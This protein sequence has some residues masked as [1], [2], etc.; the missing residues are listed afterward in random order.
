[1]PG[2]LTVAAENPGQPLALL[3]VGA[4][5]GL[6]LN[7]D[8]YRYRYSS[9]DEFGPSNSGV[10]IECDAR[11]GL[12]SLPSAF[13]RVNFRV[14]IDL[15]PV[16]LG[17]DE[18][19]LW[20]QA[21]VWPEHA[22]RGALLSAA[23]DVWL[24]SRPTVLQGDAVELLPVA[25]EDVPEDAALCVFHCHTLN[26]FSAEARA[27]FGDIL[28]A[29]SMERVVYH[30]PSE[31]DRLSLRRIV[32]GSATTLLTARRQVHGRWVAFDTHARVSPE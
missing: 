3:D 32:N 23:R 9:G 15:V 18:E 16:D 24:Q 21:L 4:S 25:L 30:M 2:F 7:W 19:Y 1:M 22:G 17:N 13:P 5:A 20:M 8:Q 11:G 10:V 14:G 27:G 28:R 31:G 6:N 26:Q 29:A 12:P